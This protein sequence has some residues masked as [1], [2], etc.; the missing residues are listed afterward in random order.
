MK[1]FAIALMAAGAEA[2]VTLP[3][4]TVDASHGWQPDPVEHSH[5]KKIWE[6]VKIPAGSI[7]GFKFE[8]EDVE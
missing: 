5:F 8:R 7:G 3:G 6:K 1:Q 4:Y 2:A